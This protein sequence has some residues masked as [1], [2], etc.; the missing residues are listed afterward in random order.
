MHFEKIMRRR[1][2]VRKTRQL[3]L[4][5]HVTLETLLA[6]VVFPLS[7]STG[8]LRGD[9]TWAE[10]LLLGDVRPR[11]AAPDFSCTHLSVPTPRQLTCSECVEKESVFAPPRLSPG[12]S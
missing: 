6:V 5:R 2:Y 10:S 12:A 11:A 1:S 4:R 8:R 7:A 9:K 3:A